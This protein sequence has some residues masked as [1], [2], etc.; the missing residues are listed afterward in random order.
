MS[1]EMDRKAPVDFAWGNI[2]PQTNKKIVFNADF[3]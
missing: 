2:V 3:S 1:T